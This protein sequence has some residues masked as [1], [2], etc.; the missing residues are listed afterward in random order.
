M[1][2]REK[3]QGLV[4]FFFLITIKDRPD[5][6][7]VLF[8]DFLAMGNILSSSADQREAAQMPGAKSITLNSHLHC[9]LP[10]DTPEEKLG[11]I[12]GC[13]SHQPAKKTIFLYFTLLL[14]SHHLFSFPTLL[15]YNLTF[16]SH[17]SFLYSLLSNQL[18]TTTTFQLALEVLQKHRPSWNDREMK[19][20]ISAFLTDRVWR[21]G[22]TGPFKWIHQ[23]SIRQILF[24]QH[25]WPFGLKVTI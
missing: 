5:Y 12:K 18:H 13:R 10:S 1:K 8:P 2:F 20:S 11:P 9:P 25:V 6:F 23:I 19:F 22:S 21:W 17:P 14:P 7:F 15:M 24:F 3:K 4:L 16:S